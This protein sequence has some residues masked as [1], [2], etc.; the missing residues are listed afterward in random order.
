M[1]WTQADIDILRGAIGTGARKVR[2]G[3]GPD[4]R[5]TEFRS[6][7]DMRSLLAEMEAAVNGTQPPDRVSFI[8]HYR[9]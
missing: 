3:A 7:A 9:G 4:S 8:E 6:L 2:F 5:E 1:A